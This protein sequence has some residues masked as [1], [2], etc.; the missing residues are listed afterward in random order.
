MSTY[1]TLPEAKS[2]L[3]HR[4][5]ATL[6][7]ADINIGDTGIV[8]S[9]YK[10]GLNYGVTVKWDHINITDGFSKSDYE[11]FLEEV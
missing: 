5:G 3:N 2:K 8:T 7:L 1:F 4:V 6:P 10:M 11:K 9:Y